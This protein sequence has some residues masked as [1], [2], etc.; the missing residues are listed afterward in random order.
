L[1]DFNMKE[2]YLTHNVTDKIKRGRIEVRRGV[3]A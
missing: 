1:A 3:V 2:N